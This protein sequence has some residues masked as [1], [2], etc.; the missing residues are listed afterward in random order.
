[1]TGEPLAGTF[2]KTPE[3]TVIEVLARSGLDFVCLD[4]EHAAF[5]RGRL[6]ACLAVCRALDF[7]ALV[8]ISSARARASSSER[9]SMETTMCDTVTSSGVTNSSS[10]IR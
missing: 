7:P 8:R 2:V 9:P 5:D 10:Y 6:D 3:V 4:G 1:M